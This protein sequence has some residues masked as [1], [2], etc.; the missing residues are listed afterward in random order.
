MKSVGYMIGLACAAA[1][2]ADAGAGDSMT[3]TS[4]LSDAFET[5]QGGLDLLV[6]DMLRKEDY[7]LRLGAGFGFVPDYRGSDDYRLKVLPLI[8]L[9]Y[10]DRLHFSYNRLSY[11][12][13]RHGHWSLGPFVKYKAGRK[14]RRNPALEGLGDIAPTAQVGIFAKYR[15]RHKLIDVD[16]RKAL[17]AGRGLSVRVMVGHALFKKGDFALA[18]LAQGKWLSQ[19]EM[20]T[21]FGVTG[22]Q[23]EGSKLGL[24]IFKPTADVS[25]VS[26]N[27]LTRYQVSENHRLVALLGYGLLV[28]EAAKSPL[29]T[30]G[31]GK[32]GQLIA[33][34][35]FTIDF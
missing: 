29:V 10:K 6:P 33:G 26:L 14:E 21:Y 25:E 28:G 17:G 24:S 30:H 5:V 7:R 11:A 2:G 15:T 12:V 13:V 34:V 22:R 20:Q 4:G 1:L 35:G 32:R 16:I 27:L 23:A 31:V 3:T 9:R 18:A 8:D 19:K